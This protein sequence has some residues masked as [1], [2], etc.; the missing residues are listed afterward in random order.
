MTSYS[1]EKRT[2]QD[3]GQ[4]IAAVNMPAGSVVYSNWFEGLS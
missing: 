1:P 2:Y 3:L 4:V